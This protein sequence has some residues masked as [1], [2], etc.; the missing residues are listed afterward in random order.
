MANR[1]NLDWSLNT[2]NERTEFVNQY[3]EL[4]QFTKIPLT[5][6]ELE[7]IANYVLWGKDDNGT[8]V[9]QRKEI[10][11][12]TRNST[13]TRKAPE[14]LDALL[15][16][17]TFN[18]NVIVQSHTPQTKVARIVFDRDEALAT[19]PES[20]RAVF[21]DLFHQIDQLDL[22]IN[23]YDLEHGKRKNPP[24]P[25]LL[26]AFSAAEQELYRTKA[27]KLT[28]YRYLKMRHL[29]VELRRQQFTLKDT[30]STPIQ[31]ES[32]APTTE[33]PTTLT[34]D[35]D[36]IVLPCGLASA[37]RQPSLVFSPMTSL[38][39]ES[40]TPHQIEHIVHTYWER[41][42]EA[43]LSSPVRIFDFRNLE[44]VSNLFTQF[45]DLEESAAL[46][47]PNSTTA[48]LLRTLEYYT[49]LAELTEA[50]QDILELKKL[51]RKNQDI[52]DIINKKHH[53][54]YTANYI[55]TIFRQKIVKQ[56]NEA[57]QYH[58]RV[59]QNLPFPEEFKV[60]STCGRP[61]LRDSHNFV[62]KTRAKDG[63]AGRCKVCDKLDRQRKKTQEKNTNV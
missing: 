52:V 25:E 38:L 53:K 19:C 5:E 44:H 56:I 34:F 60:C 63:F 23:Y 8:N 57:A 58:E 45:F 11:L 41:K 51:G 47:D 6:D 62:K 31:M 24:R 2:I 26:H 50:Q 10:E 55:S 35:S 36:I 49:Q 27:T 54:T 59:I 9:V 29:L 7:T 33:A 30:Y 39:P 20:L 40:F 3:V 22:I 48:D 28:Q 21:I 13:W 14:S 61:L 32:A 1:L 46:D 37:G 12:E 17:P 4:P 15:E 43:A 42:N 18:E 16:T